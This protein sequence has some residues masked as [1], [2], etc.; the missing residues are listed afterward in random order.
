MRGSVTRSAPRRR[1]T[2]AIIERR[3]IRRHRRDVPCFG[4][5]NTRQDRSP[6]NGPIALR[7]RSRAGSRRVGARRLTTPASTAY[8]AYRPRASHGQDGLLLPRGCPSALFTDD[9]SGPPARAGAG[10]HIQSFEVSDFFVPRAGLVLGVVALLV[11]MLLAGP[12]YASLEVPW[13]GPN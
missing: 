3:V 2:Q 13:H 10:G 8:F 1:A 5:L 6:D 9:G 7:R 4:R 11:V 12:A